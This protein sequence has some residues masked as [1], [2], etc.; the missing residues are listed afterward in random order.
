MRWAPHVLGAVEGDF[1]LYRTSPNRFVAS[2]G[3]SVE[4]CP[5]CGEEPLEVEAQGIADRPEAAICLAALI[6]KLTEVDET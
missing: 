2:F 3:Y 4:E 5:E 6:A 1:I